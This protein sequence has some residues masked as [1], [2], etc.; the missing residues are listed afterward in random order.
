MFE[1]GLRQEHRVPG[2]VGDQ[3]KSLL[4]HRCN[5]VR[6]RNA[7]ILADISQMIPGLEEIIPPFQGLLKPRSILPT[8]ML[9]AYGDA[10]T[11]RRVFENGV[12]SPLTRPIKTPCSEI[13]TRPERAAL[14]HEFAAVHEAVHGPPQPRRSRDGATAF[15]GISAA[16]LPENHIR[17]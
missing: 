9:A 15:R 2:D 6:E 3:K 4:R 17:S 10:E 11:K 16:V 14:L 13:E 8:I 7:I 1:F 5:P 12:E